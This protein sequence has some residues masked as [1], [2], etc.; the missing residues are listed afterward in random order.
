MALVLSVRLNVGASANQMADLNTSF[1]SSLFFLHLGLLSSVHSLSPSKFSPFNSTQTRTAIY[2]AVKRSVLP[3]LRCFSLAP[4][5]RSD[6]S[7][8]RRGKRAIGSLVEEVANRSRFQ[9]ILLFFLCRFPTETM[10]Q[11]S[12]L[13]S[14]L[15]LLNTLSAMTTMIH[16][17]STHTM[18]KYVGV[19]G[20][21]CTASERARERFESVA[22]AIVACVNCRS[23]TRTPPA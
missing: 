23:G 17:F 2:H 15:L 21:C 6:P 9:V 22:A 18:T 12:P 20:S 1:L 8:H 3:F 16:A 13:S 10:V 5:V 14:A 7:R 19:I 11:L 4:L